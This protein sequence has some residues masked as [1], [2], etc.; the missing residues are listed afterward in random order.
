MKSKIL[1]LGVGAAMAATSLQSCNDLNEIVDVNTA[2]NENSGIDDATAISMKNLSEEEQIYI[3]DMSLLSHT[4]LNDTTAA[5]HFLI[6]PLEYAQ[7]LGI[8]TPINVDDGTVRFL[9]AI[10]KPEFRDALNKRDIKL[11]VQLCDDNEIFKN[12]VSS[13][14]NL[15]NSNNITRS[16]CVGDV[17]MG[18]FWLGE[19]IFIGV[20][21]AGV[22]VDYAALGVPK[23][24]PVC[25]ANMVNSEMALQI[26]D[27]ETQDG[28]VYNLADEYKN[29]YTRDLIDLI[30]DKHPEVI[31]Q[32]SDK[33]L[34]EIIQKTLRL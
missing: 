21:Y 32:Y 18:F 34:A 22:G 15:W 28:S 29:H 1:T 2:I 24:P 27:A 6:N 16:K 13:N 23:V 10:C 26:W 33:E 8:K 7:S 20:A 5:G 30:K 4:I 19:W 25:V 14:I 17:E 31:E 3:H 11:F 9:L 12:A